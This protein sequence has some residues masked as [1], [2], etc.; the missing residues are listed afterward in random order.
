MA[1]FLAKLLGLLI[2]WVAAFLRRDYDKC[3]VLL[4]IG[5]PNE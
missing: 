4:Q 3:F 2:V 5:I 1:L